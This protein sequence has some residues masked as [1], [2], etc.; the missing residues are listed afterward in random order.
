MKD[1][2]N[3]KISEVKGVGPKMNQLLNKINIY[4]IFDCLRY[5]PRAYEDLSTTY[6]LKD[7]IAE[8]GLFYLEV[9]SN[10]IIRRIRPNLDIMNLVVSDG[11]DTA[12]LTFFNSSFLKKY[13]K[14]GY[15]KYIYGEVKRS[16][17]GL[18]IVQGQIIKKTE[19]GVLNPIYNLTAGLTNNFM[20]KLL[21]TALDQYSPYIVDYL[22][23]ELLAEL[24]IVDLKTAINY[25]HYPRSYKDLEYARRRLAFDELFILQA[26][27]DNN[28]YRTEKKLGPKIFY[29]KY[30]E[31]IE[32]YINSFPFSL[33]KAQKRVT[34]EIFSD[35]ESS[36]MNRLLQGDVG[37][38]KTIVASLVAYLTYLNGYQ[39]A[40]MVPTEILAKQHFKSFFK[41][42]STFGPQIELLTG[43]TSEKDKALILEKL[44]NGKIDIIVGTHSLI[45]DS[46]E[47]SNLGLTIIDEQHRFG[48]DQRKSLYLK[49]NNPHNLSMTATPIPRTLALIIYGDMEISSIDELPPG[50]QPVDTIVIDDSYLE[51]LDTF[52]IK[53]IQAGRQVF[54]VCPLIENSDTMDLNSV[55]K[56]FNRYN[57]DNFKANN[58]KSVFLHGKMKNSEKDEIMNE[59][60]NGNIDIIVSTTVIEVGINVPNANL[61]IIY[62]ADRF[63]LSQLHQLRGRV[64]RGQEKSYCVLVNNNKTELA[65]RRMKVMKQ[66]SDGFFISEMDLELRGQGELMGTR[67]HGISDF[68]FINLK[69]DL[70]L[71]DYVK[72]NYKEIYEKI[73]TDNVLYSQLEFYLINNSKD[74]DSSNN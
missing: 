74:M 8:K 72:K 26:V 36:N 35:L 5:Y 29:K 30:Q 65:Y 49:G 12:E 7:K 52:I 1:L 67:Q 13:F 10:P 4:S 9:L 68:Q 41:D 73:K 55:E 14:I 45:Q 69:N 28:N 43:S 22:P 59:F 37:S 39:T 20:R 50:R 23:R 16:K 61:I 38:G 70:Q 24:K 17:N 11:V 54:V 63:G 71:I 15:K 25:I 27:L 31:D 53:Q 3:I 66:S 58:I 57:T 64:G 51:R 6:K 48:V 34:E 46:V 47:F 19:I 21:K 42:L 18:Q 60:A 33:T 2:N 44:K 40:V 56:V 32:R 62:D